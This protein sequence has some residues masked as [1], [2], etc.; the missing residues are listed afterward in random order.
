MVVGVIDLQVDFGD[1]MVMKPR[2]FT[3]R[4]SFENGIW[5][6]YKTSLH[7]LQIHAKINR[8]QVGQGHRAVSG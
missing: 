7:Q 4:R 6:Q 8:L 5:L 2:T 3:I 1:M